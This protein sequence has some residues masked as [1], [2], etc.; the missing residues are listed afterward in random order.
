MSL[1][2]PT[3]S[4]INEVIALASKSFYREFRAI[5]V[6]G[7][8]LDGNELFA[9]HFEA[10]AKFVV[11]LLPEGTLLAECFESSK[12]ST[13]P[14]RSGSRWRPLCSSSQ[15]VWTR[16]RSMSLRKAPVIVLIEFAGGVCGGFTAIPFED[17]RHVAD[18]TGTSFVFSLRPKAQR[19]QLADRGTRSAW[20]S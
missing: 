18:S 1:S 12:P 4:T 2:V 5:S 8:Q 15:R 3:R 7:Q 10:D 17:A 9:D 20:V 6:F 13:R 19:Y 11:H 14:N 16:G